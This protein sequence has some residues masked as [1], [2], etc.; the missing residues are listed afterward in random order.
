MKLSTAFSAAVLAAA[1]AMPAQADEPIH[2]W[3]GLYVGGHV[4]YADGDWQGT[5]HT[6]GSKSEDIWDNPNQ[7][8]GFNGWL[9]GL[10]I[11]ANRQHGSLVWGIEADASWG[12][13]EG[14]KEVFTKTKAVSW[15]DNFSVDAF[16]TVRGRLGFLVTPR[17]LL[18]GTGGLAWAKADL[19]HTVV[20]NPKNNP[21]ITV[22]ASADE[23]H[24]GWVAGAGTEFAVAD[25]WTVRGEWLHVN[26][27][28]ARYHAVGMQWS[29]NQ[30]FDKPVATDSI[31]DTTLEF[32]IFRVGVNYRFGS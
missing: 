12:D 23:Y 2:N 15:I 9:G 8:Y 3:S 20:D 13:L 29:Q 27:G 6:A 4:G 14:S 19:N 22:K 30:Q 24:L 21:G 10:Q 16:G 11:G 17:L 31:T 5:L 32:D 26:L 1:F 18:Y 25:N 28:E 7:S